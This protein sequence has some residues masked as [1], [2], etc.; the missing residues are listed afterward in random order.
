MSNNADCNVQVLAK[1]EH[2]IKGSAVD[3]FRALRPANV[4]L[5]L[6]DMPPYI[7]N[8]DLIEYFRFGRNFGLFVNS[9]VYIVN[10]ARC[11]I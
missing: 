7:K 4:K 1:A 10:S 3:V 11:A 8:K 9:F 5:F 2:V 6:S